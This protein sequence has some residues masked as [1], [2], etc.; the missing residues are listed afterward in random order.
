MSDESESKSAADTAS[1]TL[2]ASV[3]RAKE[4]LAALKAALRS[5]QTGEMAEQVSATAA[6]LLREGE[7]FIE[8]NETLKTAR[9]DL[10]GAVQRNPL[11]AVAIA[12]GAG[13]LVALLTRG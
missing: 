13:L 10:A 3:R 8:N 4:A 12:F 1:A 5:G 2:D 9:K 11:G 7:E 6:E